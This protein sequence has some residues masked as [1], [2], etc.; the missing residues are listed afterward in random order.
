[1]ASS[2]LSRKLLALTLCATV[3]AG[4]AA[5]AAEVQTEEHHLGEASSSKATRRS[6]TRRRRLSLPEDYTRRSLLPEVM[7]SMKRNP[8]SRRR[9]RAKCNLW[10][11][12][13]DAHN[14]ICTQC[15]TGQALMYWTHKGRAGGCKTFQL[16][17]VQSYCTPLGE[18]LGAFGKPGGGGFAAPGE[19]RVL[20]SKASLAEA[21]THTDPDPY[22][23]YPPP[24][25]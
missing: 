19:A 11:K 6:T 22:S 18:G 16:N 25:R 23:L 2:V 5:E 3:F 9:L 4:F 20:C 1:M 10:M 17:K 13:V 14:P 24:P 21:L 15:E 8:T 12:S 7:T